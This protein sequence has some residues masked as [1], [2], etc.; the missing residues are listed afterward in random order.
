MT[1]IVAAIVREPGTPFELARLTLSDP[2]P[3][4]VLVRIAGVGVC[5]TDIVAVSGHFP[6]TMPAV[7]GHE[8]AGIVEKVGEAVTKLRPGDR[9]AMTFMSCGTCPRCQRDAFPYCDNFRQLNFSGTRLDGSRTLAESGRLVSGSFFSQSSFASHA[10]AHERNLAK[11]PEGV[12]LD[13]V[14][15]LGCG[16]QTGAGAILRSLDCKPGRSLVVLGGGA[17]G[18]AAVMAAKVRDLGSVVLVEPH[19]ARRDLAKE[20][21]A[22]HVVDPINEPAT[23]RIRAILPAGADYVFDT[24]GVKSVIAI[25]PNILAR[26]GAFG[27]VGV[28]APANIEMP[29]P[30][31]LVAAMGNG[32]T[33]RG[34]I[35][36]DSD[37]DPFL[38]ELM[39]L[40]LAGRF[41]FD[42]IVTRSKLLDINPAID[43][44]HAGRCTK[45]VLIP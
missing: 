1:P 12:P 39:A 9:V 36:G 37:I 24:S 20:L 29:L 2:R 22:T 3:D 33:F 25:V 32:W 43:D 34:I 10:L 35:E 26:L 8:G 4:E 38:E 19:A 40:Y 13:I 41:P 5:H 21:G 45:P 28:P 6:L 30:G 42:R 18:L 27:F 14:G 15:V 31:S 7:L 23:E 11:V 44:Q 16:I 17:V